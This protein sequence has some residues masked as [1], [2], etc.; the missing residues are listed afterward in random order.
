MSRWIG[1]LEK[2]ETSQSSWNKMQL[3]QAVLSTRKTSPANVTL[4]LDE[5]TQVLHAEKTDTKAEL[6]CLIWTTYISRKKACVQFKTDTDK[7]NNLV[8]LYCNNWDPKTSNWP[9]SYRKPEYFSKTKKSI[10]LHLRLFKRCIV[11]DETTNHNPNRHH[12][13]KPFPFCWVCTD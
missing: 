3:Y 5:M 6:F 8:Y 4:T 1:N 12:D 11:G 10:K 7:F 13:E 2:K 9:K